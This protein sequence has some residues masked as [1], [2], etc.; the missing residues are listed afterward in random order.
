MGVEIE[1]KFLV[2]PTQWAKI[3]PLSTVVI[4][5]G[6]LTSSSSPVVRVRTLGE[7]GFL[8]VKGKT[9][10]IS[11]KEFEYEIPFSEASALI[12]LF[13][14]KY[15]HKLRH[16]I[17]VGHHEWVVDEFIHPHKGLLLA[18]VELTHEQ[19]AVELPEWVTEE[20]SNDP[21]YYNSNMLV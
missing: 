5:Q 17:K 1:R 8:T 14:P 19:E 21:R 11:R 18:E 16:E 4:K 2:D 9:E 6:Y 15:I 3:N 10:G 13:C 12:E 7:K 20:V